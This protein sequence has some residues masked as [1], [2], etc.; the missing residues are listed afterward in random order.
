MT[1]Q[2]IAASKTMA[3][4]KALHNKVAAGTATDDERRQA[5]RIGKWLIEKMGREYF[6]NCIGQKRAAEIEELFKGRL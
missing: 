4:Y 5:I 2:N 3:E 1:L 6:L